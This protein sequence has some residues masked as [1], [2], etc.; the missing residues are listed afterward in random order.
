MEFE[1]ALVNGLIGDFGTV[2]CF[3]Y[4]WLLFGVSLDRWQLLGFGVVTFTVLSISFGKM[5]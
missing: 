2:L 5:N 3:F 1:S 4:D